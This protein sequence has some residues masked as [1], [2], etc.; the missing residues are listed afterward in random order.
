V[1][2]IIRQRKKFGFERN[3]KKLKSPGNLDD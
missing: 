2:L 1:I 3:Q